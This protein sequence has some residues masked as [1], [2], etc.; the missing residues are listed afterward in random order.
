[1]IAELLL[2]RKGG[3]LLDVGCGSVFFLLLMG[4]GVGLDYGENVDICI[5]R[6]LRAFQLDW[7]WSRSH[8]PVSLPW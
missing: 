3:S 4:E 1:M 8:S 2:D 5:R 7:K 6:G